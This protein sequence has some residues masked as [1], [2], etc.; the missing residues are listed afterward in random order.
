MLGLSCRRVAFVYVVPLVL[1]TFFLAGSSTASASYTW[2]RSDPVVVVD[3]YTM[4]VFVSVPLDDLSKVT[5][6]TEIVVITPPGTDVALATL[7]VGFGYGEHVAFEDS[8]SL[9][10]TSQGME[11]RVEVF[12]PTSDNSVPVNLQVAPRI[13]G[14]LSPTTDAGHA[15]Q[16][17]SQQVVI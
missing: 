15:N 17:V 2:C 12:V 4:D 8:P 11:I 6:A 10:V 16:W 3:G 9:S 14:I 1:L 13:I 5:G 7:G